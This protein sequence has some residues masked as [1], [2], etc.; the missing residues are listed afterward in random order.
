MKCKSHCSGAQVVASPLALSVAPSSERGPDHPFQPVLL[1]CRHLG[2]NPLECDCAL[3]WLPRWLLERNIRLVGTE[4]A[5]CGGP[6]PLAGQPLLGL[7][8]LDHACGEWH[9]GWPAGGS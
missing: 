6:G 5:T 8:W 1:P 3:A 4:V 9:P 7:P 2:G